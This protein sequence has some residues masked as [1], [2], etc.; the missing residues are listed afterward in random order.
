MNSKEHPSLKALSEQQ[1]MLISG[2]FIQSFPSYKLKMSNELLGL[3][4]FGI[5]PPTRPRPEKN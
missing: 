3:S 4:S 1:I 2:G 5:P